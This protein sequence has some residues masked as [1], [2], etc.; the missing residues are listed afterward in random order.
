MPPQ[1]PGGPFLVTPGTTEH[2]QRTTSAVSI[3]S[4]FRRSAG[5][6]GSS[7]GGSKSAPRVHH[8][9]VDQEMITAGKPP[10]VMRYLSEVLSEMGMDVE[11]EGDY[12]YRCSRPA[13]RRDRRDVSDAPVGGGSRVFLGVLGRRQP[14][15]ARAAP[16]P[17]NDPGNS[18]SAL[19]GEQ[20]L[21]SDTVYGDASEDVGD[22]VR[23]SVELTRLDRLK[24]THSVDVRRLKGNLKSYK[25]IYDTLRM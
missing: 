6:T 12:K 14:S 3:T 2:R 9:A 20:T 11:V 21:R 22:E 5:V 23:F 24:D 8:G 15:P 13:K 10:E 7:T 1:S 4:L 18:S 17:E 16:P 19:S 25:F